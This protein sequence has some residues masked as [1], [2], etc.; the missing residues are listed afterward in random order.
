MPLPRLIGDPDTWQLVY[1]A[2]EN[3]FQLPFPPPRLRP[4]DSSVCVGTAYP[5][6][7][8]D[9]Y[10]RAS[11][12]SE[13]PLN[14]TGVRSRAES[15][16]A[17]VSLRE[18]PGGLQKK[19]FGSPRSKCDSNASQKHVMMQL[20]EMWRKPPRWSTTRNWDNVSEGVKPLAENLKPRFWLQKHRK[21]E[22]DMWGVESITPFLSA[23]SFACFSKPRFWLQ[24][25]TNNIPKT[26][27][28]VGART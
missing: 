23:A 2:E 4:N 18:D 1:I 3:K 6:K 13:N 10:C 9:S 11:S 19:V 25:F 27:W 26:N 20:W 16:L 17:L 8:S 22:A 5:Q 21:V 15:P 28:L 24:L 14:K 7:S 12:R